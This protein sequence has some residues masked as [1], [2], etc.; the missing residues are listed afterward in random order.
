M[1]TKKQQ[2]AEKKSKSTSDLLATGS[3][4]TVL[5]PV[6]NEELII[7]PIGVNSIDQGAGTNFLRRSISAVVNEVHLATGTMP[8][9][10]IIKTYT[11]DNLLMGTSQINNPFNFQVPTG[12]PAIADTVNGTIS[13]TCSKETE[14]LHGPNYY[15]DYDKNTLFGMFCSE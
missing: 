9:T 13:Y 11:P 8:Q 7:S 3:Y 6:T 5:H 2:E 1:K 10:L 14:K 12:S 4:T 15:S